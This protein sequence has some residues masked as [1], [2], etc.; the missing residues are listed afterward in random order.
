[1]NRGVITS[2]GGAIRLKTANREEDEMSESIDATKI[3]EGFRVLAGPSELGRVSEIVTT[4]S[5]DERHLCVRQAEGGDL[6][7]P[8]TS[9]DRVDEVQN[10]IYLDA[11]G[12]QEI[13]ERGWNRPPG[14]SS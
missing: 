9:I 5:G 2:V 12:A 4:G 11:D 6:W 10:V 13:P 8:L 14:V 7:I 3:R 1:M